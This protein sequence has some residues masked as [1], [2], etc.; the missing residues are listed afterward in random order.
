VALMSR[1]RRKNPIC[2][3][4]KAESEKEDKQ[5]ANRVF[6][7]REK[8][9]I[10]KRKDPPEDI[11]EVITDWDMAKDGKQRFDP[12]RWPEGMRK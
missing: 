7:R 6:R 5:R 3:N 12:E 2:G 9:A 4:A 1:S 10:R 8:D 11:N